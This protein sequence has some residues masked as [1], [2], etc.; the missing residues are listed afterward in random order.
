MS[1]LV[2]VLVATLA[3]GLSSCDGGAALDPMAGF[4]P[5]PVLPEP[6]RSLIPTVNIAEAVGWP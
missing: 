3:I 5:D 2:S 6:Q 1:R 4:G